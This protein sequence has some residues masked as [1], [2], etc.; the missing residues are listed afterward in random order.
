MYLYYVAD[1]RF[2]QGDYIYFLLSI[3]H[4]IQESDSHASIFIQL[5][6]S[7]ATPFTLIMLTG[8][9]CIKL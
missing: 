2:V 7:S 4:S 9:E 1:W 3:F 5:N 6:Y 8:V